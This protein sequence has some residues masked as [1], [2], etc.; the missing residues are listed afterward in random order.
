MTGPMVFTTST[1]GGLTDFVGATDVINGDISP[2]VRASFDDTTSALAAVGVHEVELSVTN[3]LGDT[4]RLV[5]PVRVVEDSIHSESL[6]LKDYLV[7]VKKG[8]GFDPNAYFSQDTEED[9][10]DNDREKKDQ[11]QISSNVNTSAPGVYAV[12]YTLIHNEMTAAM[13]RLIVVVTD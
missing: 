3:S 1:V 2:K 10:D 7:Y 5:V 4:S 12:D 6:P 9:G 8:E 11:V 13:T